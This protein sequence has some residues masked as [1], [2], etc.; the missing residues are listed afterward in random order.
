MGVNN[1]TK[2]GA[3]ESKCLQHI[4]IRTE[5]DAVRKRMEPFWFKPLLKLVR[6]FMS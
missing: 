1:C 3:C 2:C 4:A 5:L 6:A